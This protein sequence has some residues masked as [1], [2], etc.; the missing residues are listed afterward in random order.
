MSSV[1]RT[2]YRLVDLSGFHPPAAVTS[3]V[4]GAAKR[5]FDAL[6]IPP[7][8]PRV[9]DEGHV[10]VHVRAEHGASEDSSALGPLGFLLL[11][12][13]SLGFLVA[14][15]R[16]RTDRAHGA[17]ALAL[18]LYVVALALGTRWNLYVDRFLVT[19][20]ALTLPLA[21]AVLRRVPVQRRRR[22][23]SPPRRSRSRSPTTCRSRRGVWN[24]SRADAQAIRWPEL[25]PVL[26]AVQARVPAHAR[27]GVDLAPLD[28]EYPFWGP[29]LGGGSSGF[30]SSPPPGSTGCCS[31]RRRRAAA[32]PL[33][34]AAL[35]VGRAGRCSTAVSLRGDGR[36]RAHR[37]AR[38]RGDV[39]DLARRA[40][41]RGR[42]RGRAH[43]AAASAATARR[44][45]SSA[46][47]SR[48][49]SALAYVE[50]HAGAAR[51][52]PVRARGDHGAAAARASTRRA[53]RSTPRCTTC[54]ASSS[55]GPVYQL[56]GL[57]RIGPP[58]S[59][60]IWLGDPDD[61]A[62]RAEKVRRPLQA[63]EAE[64]R[65]PAT[66]S[67]SSA[68]A[69]CSG[70]ADVPL[71][72]DV[73]EAWTL[74]EALDALPQLAEL[75]VEYCEQPLA[76]GDPG[77][78]RAEGGAR[79]SRS[80]STRTATRSRDVARVRRARARR[81]TSS[82]RSPGG[83]REA[84][85]MVHAARALGLG[86]MLG[87]MVESGLGIAAG[88][89]IASLF[90]HVDLDGNILHRA[91]PVARRRV[92]RRRPGARRAA[93]ARR[94]AARRDPLPDPRRG[95]L[96]PTRTT[97]RRCA[98]CCATGAT[99]SSRSS[100]RRARRAR[101]RTACPIVA[102]V[103][104]ALR[105]E[106]NTA[107]VGVATQGGRFPPAWMRAPAQLHRAR[108]RRRERPARL[109]RRRSRAAASSRRGTASSC[110]TCAGRRRI[111]RP[112]PARTSTC[113]A[114]IVLT[115]GSDCAIGKMTVSLEL[116]LEARRRGLA[117]DLRPDRADRDRDRRLGDLRRRRRRRLHRRRR[118]AARRRGRRARAG[119]LLWVEG[120]G[121]IIHPGLLRRHARPL[122]R[123]RA[124]PARPLPRGRGRPR[125]R[126]PAAGRI[127]SRRC[128]EL[129]ELHERLALPAR[130]ARVAAIALNTRDLD[131][132]EAPGGDRGGRG[133]DR[134]PGRR[135]GP[136]RRREDPRRVHVE[137][138]SAVYANGSMKG[139]REPGMRPRETHGAGAR[140]CSRG[141]TVRKMGR[142]AG[143]WLLPIDDVTGSRERKGQS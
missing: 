6:H 17:F 49:E 123:Q 58:T 37:H 136:L 115:V 103:D 15:A 80:T 28:W 63:A 82:S 24:L 69:R 104:D 130:P 26:E 132:D 2:G 87:C 84:V 4:A 35:P 59:W 8:P 12:P 72:V 45:R 127:R 61:M 140:L 47:T 39:R 108:A 62:R 131:E 118:R 14:W 29:R 74:D 112:R 31:A 105:F 134:A 55:G 97:A 111:S 13:L 27:L 124:A 75:G 128:A 70:V 119:E 71:Q 79:R 76:A 96:A 120:Q 139:T 34:R 60:T 86:C 64:A 94:R 42:R 67:T 1:A 43:A 65:R 41:H 25:R 101:R 68:C 33:V 66:G 133:R 7:N 85:R 36:H 48:R 91:R 21:P 51:R 46:T 122:P 5:V 102:T 30:R 3:H 99:T 143:T 52:R 114:T 83:I 22:G 135:P 88:A 126:A 11:V 78:P 98:A 129:V 89:H 54:R 81:S 10:R 137:R 107:L 113:P 116:D 50:E 93:R 95:L 16:R 106:P 18:P 142:S 40:R 100:T 73:N 44:R 125:S 23:R 77:G 110:A 141:R 57:P 53:P 109:P 56:L 19:P 38:A 121:S 20:A 9:D 92:R 117:L 32:G 90:D 138:R